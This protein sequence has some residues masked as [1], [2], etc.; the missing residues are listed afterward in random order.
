MVTITMHWRAGVTAAEAATAGGSS[1]FSSVSNR[2]LAATCFSF[3]TYLCSLHTP[4][5]GQ[6]SNGVSWRHGGPRVEEGSPNYCSTRSIALFA[7]SAFMFIYLLYICPATESSTARFLT[8]ASTLRDMAS[9]WNPVRTVQSWT[10][11]LKHCRYNNP[12]T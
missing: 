10:R 5:S 4:C 7:R 3:I 11:N 8:S 6:L 9:I 12:S 2:G 1:K